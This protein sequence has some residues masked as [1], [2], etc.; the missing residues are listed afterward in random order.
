MLKTVNRT[1]ENTL[2]NNAGHEH[3]SSSQ[4]CVLG[5]L[6]AEQKSYETKKLHKHAT[7]FNTF[8]FWGSRDFR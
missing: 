1:P 5:K 7:I 3:L 4:K 8:K 6:H 2:Q